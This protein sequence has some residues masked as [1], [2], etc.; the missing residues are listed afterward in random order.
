[1]SKVK[2]YVCNGVF[3]IEQKYRDITAWELKRKKYH[4]AKDWIKKISM[5]GLHCPYCGQCL[6]DSVL[7]K[8][9]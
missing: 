1:M 6:L 8:A 2:C 9:V 5:R 7:K 4:I 3:G